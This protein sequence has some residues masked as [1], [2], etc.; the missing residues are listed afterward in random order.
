MIFISYSLFRCSTILNDINVILTALLKSEI[1][2][3]LLY[4][5]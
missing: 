5:F 3:K 2:T 1:E 4:F